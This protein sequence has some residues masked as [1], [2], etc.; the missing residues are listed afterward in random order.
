MLC[1]KSIN[2]FDVY[3]GDKLPKE[4]EVI[5]ALILFL[6]I[7]TKTLTDKYIDGIMKKLI[8]EYV[9]ASWC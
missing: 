5:R 7:I 3:N 8:K 6:K 9:S 4:Q 1:L 2:L